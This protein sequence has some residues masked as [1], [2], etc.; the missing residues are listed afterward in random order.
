MFWVAKSKED[1]SVEDIKNS[2]LDYLKNPGREG[3]IVKVTRKDGQFA[4]DFIG[5]LDGDLIVLVVHSLYDSMTDEQKIAL[6]QII[7]SD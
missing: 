3:L 2:L 4:V 7:S 6:Q 5:R 1:V